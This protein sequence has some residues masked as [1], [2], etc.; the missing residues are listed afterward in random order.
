MTS[1][2]LKHLDM[3]DVRSQYLVRLK[4]S[5]RLR[6]LMD[7]ESV[8]AFV[9]LALGISD[10][11]GNYSASDHNLGPKILDSVP[12]VAVFQLA[13][14]LT[15]SVTSMAMLAEVYSAN[16]PYLKV[17]VGSEIAML[18]K[19]SSFWVANT[20]SVWAHLLIK[21]Q[22]NYSIADEELALYRDQDS[23]SEMEYRKWREIHTLMKSN[24]VTLGELGDREAERNGI[25][26]GKKRFVWFDALANALYD[27]KH[28]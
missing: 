5:K 4:T 11:S 1:R 20:R 25:V 17:S 14:R 10:L 18:L 7:S 13:R 2:H 8:E 16:I 6:G 12:P 27:Y 26:P 23:T 21:H 3:G 28:V 15:T 24:L 19:P 22:F 9:D